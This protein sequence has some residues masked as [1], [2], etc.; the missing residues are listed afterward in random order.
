MLNK[1]RNSYSQN[2]KY[3]LHLYRTIREREKGLSTEARVVQYGTALRYFTKFLQTQETYSPQVLSVLYWIYTK[4]GDIY[5]EDGLQKQD[6]TRFLLA[7]EYYNQA[8]SYAYGRESKNRIL[9][10]LRNIY[11]YLNDEKAL[12][13]VEEAWVENQGEEERFDAYTFLAR[14]AE[15]P[16]IK[17]RFLEKAL[18]KVTSQNESFYTK[19]RDTLDL[20][21]QLIVVYEILGE[22]EK[23]NRIKQLRENTLKI[24]N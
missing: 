6:N 9:L 19:Y 18:D 10:V 4:L 21:S 16:Q 5:Y 23:L 1:V 8:L 3:F 24:L 20:C 17:A 15:Y 13:Q 7:T 22:N 2:E 12:A 11:Y 14:T